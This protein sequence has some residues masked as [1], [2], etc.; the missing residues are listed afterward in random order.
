MRSGPNPELV[1]LR[2]YSLPSG[3]QRK[4]LVSSA[5]AVT[6]SCRRCSPVPVGFPCRTLTDESGRRAQ[7]LRQAG[8]CCVY[9]GRA[10][11]EDRARAS[12]AAIGDGEPSQSLVETVRSVNQRILES[13]REPLDET[14]I[15]QL[16]RSYIETKAADRRIM[17]QRFALLKKRTDE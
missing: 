2:S 1:L 13:V 7:F 17:E 8:A 14:S 11:W 5:I 9:C 10:G 12:L 15:A 3:S 16:H 6:E 4:S